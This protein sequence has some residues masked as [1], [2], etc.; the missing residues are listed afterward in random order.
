MPD[1]RSLLVGAAAVA[2]VAGGAGIAAAAVADQP[3]PHVIGGEAVTSAPSFIAAVLDREGQSCGGTL[4]APSWVVTAAHCDWP[5][6]V[7]VR[8]GSVSWKSG[9]Q[10]R[11][12]AEFIRYP[13][14]GPGRDLALIRLDRPT[15]LAPATIAAQVEPGADVRMLGWGD[16][17]E[18]HVDEACSEAPAILHKLDTKLTRA[19]DCGKTYGG[20]AAGQEWCVQAR[21]ESQGCVG[22]SGGPLLIRAGQDWQVIGATSRDG[23]D[24]PLCGSGPGVWT[25]L[26]AHRAWITETMRD[27]TGG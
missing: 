19:E 25:N 2:F 17:C 24:D 13:S 9:G 12:V 16:V 1:L 20:F 5:E 8:V 22:D 23:D 21:G 26:L 11:D 27:H 14:S 18:A 3:G 6:P 15:D 4:I 10:L 7:Q